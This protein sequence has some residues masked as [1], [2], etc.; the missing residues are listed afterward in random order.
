MPY[1][2]LQSAPMDADTVVSRMQDHVRQ[3]EEQDARLERE[4]TLLHGQRAAIANEIANIEIAIRYFDEFRKRA[5]AASANQT[6]LPLPLSGTIADAAVEV[7]RQK[8][9]EVE[10]GELHERLL[11]AGK[12][13]PTPH[14]RTT[15]WKTL[16]RKKDLFEKAGAGRWRLSGTI[17]SPL[18]DEVTIVTR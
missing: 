14:S 7:I 18:D 11:A 3:L 10:L 1:G 15:L 8:G 12:L 16:D 6:A 4:L 2:S 9:G 17:G 13:K 5:P